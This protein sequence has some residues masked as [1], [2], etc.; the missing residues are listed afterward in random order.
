MIEKHLDPAILDK[1]YHFPFLREIELPSSGF[2]SEMIKI[3]E[4]IP[5][6]DSTIYGLEDGA[7]PFDENPSYVLGKVRE[8]FYYM[9][10]QVE[11][12]K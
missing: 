3:I 12:K 2:T 5:T 10:T 6:D 7:K 9:D 4:E 11:N 1:N 8:L